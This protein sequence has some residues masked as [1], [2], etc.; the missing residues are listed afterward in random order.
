M[1]FEVKIEKRLKS[2][3]ES[4]KTLRIVDYLRTTLV[5]VMRGLYCGERYPKT[6]V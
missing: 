5:L 6:E 4:G 2:I 1:D 3:K